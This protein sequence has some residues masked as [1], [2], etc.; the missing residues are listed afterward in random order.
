MVVVA[1]VAVAVVDGCIV[2]VVGG[3]EERNWRGGGRCY[4]TAA[5]T[6]D[7]GF[8]SHRSRF[9]AFSEGKRRLI[10]KPR[11]TPKNILKYELFF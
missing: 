3:G 2:V 5:N 1:A 7:D 11:K 4:T 6:G 10:L 9:C 8:Y